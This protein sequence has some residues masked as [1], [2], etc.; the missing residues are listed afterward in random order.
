MRTAALRRLVAP[1]LL[2]MLVSGCAGERAA[3]SR[4]PESHDPAT[5]PREEG[6]DGAPKP[7]VTPP[8]PNEGQ[9]APLE[10]DEPLD[11]DGAPP[12]VPQN[13]LSDKKPL[14]GDDDG[15]G[16][17]SDE[18]GTSED[19]SSSSSRDGGSRS[20]RPRPVPDSQGVAPEEGQEQP[21]HIDPVI[22]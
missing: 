11:T 22:P 7:V 6:V 13:E 1:L 4:D 14:E 19:Q 10:Q 15:A 2:A 3:S 16:T 9:T 18:G 17:S 8:V 21:L 20:Q 5:A 12:A